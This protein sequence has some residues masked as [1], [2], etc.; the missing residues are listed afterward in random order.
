MPR[1]RRGTVMSPQVCRTAPQYHH[2]APSHATL[3]PAPPRRAAPRRAE[4]APSPQALTQECLPRRVA[5]RCLALPC[6]ASPCLASPCLALPRP[7]PSTTTNI[8]ATAVFTSNTHNPQRA[9]G[10]SYLAL[11]E[12]KDRFL[13]SSERGRRYWGACR[14]RVETLRAQVGPVILCARTVKPAITRS[15]STTSSK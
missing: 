13:P 3:S 1:R 4:V 5:S 7:S 15:T 11:N 10:Q 14:A 12:S 6:L 9:L 2:A 8:T